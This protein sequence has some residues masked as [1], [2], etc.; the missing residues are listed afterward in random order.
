MLLDV[1][2]AADILK[3][4]TK[5]IYRW[6][7]A[8][9][10]PHVRAGNQY[11]FSRAELLAWAGSSGKTVEPTAVHESEALETYL[12]SVH[13]ALR[14]GGIFYRVSGST[15]EEVFRE[16]ASIL[17][18]PPGVDRKYLLECL[19][20][21]EGLA[22]TGV[23]EGVAIPHPRHPLPH[24]TRCLLSLCFLEKPIDWKAV[25][26]VP[27]HAVFLLLCPTTRSHLHLMSHLAFVLREPGVRELLRSEASRRDILSGI[28]EAE[29]LLFAQSSRDVS[30]GA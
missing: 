24:L 4:S 22:S 3:V 30:N 18:V 29:K 11:R 17:N 25:D 7:S 12:P 15:T 13:E 19:T 26:S 23:G 1:R 20:A 10:I 2:E 16:A 8:K 5:T 28:G 14:D 27:V 6:L 9:K 21:R